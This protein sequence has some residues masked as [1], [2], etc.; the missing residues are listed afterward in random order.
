MSEKTVANT[1][2]DYLSKGP[3]I[4]LIKEGTYYQERIKC[5]IREP[6]IKKSNHR[7][8]SY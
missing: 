7:R 5:S 1:K 6:C 4:Q 3:G 2:Y 8:T